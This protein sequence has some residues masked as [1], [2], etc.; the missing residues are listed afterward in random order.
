M[1]LIFPGFSLLT[2]GSVISTLAENT[3]KGK[4]FV[5]RLIPSSD[6]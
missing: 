3:A 2:L 6:I 5:G 1:S 4:R